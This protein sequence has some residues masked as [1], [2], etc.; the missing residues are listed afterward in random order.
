[1]VVKGLNRHDLGRV[2]QNGFYQRQRLHLVGKHLGQ[3]QGNRG[4][5][6]VPDQMIAVLQKPRSNIRNLIVYIAFQ[7]H[8]CALAMHRHIKAAHR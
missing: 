5:K 6:A 7:G 4:P 3:T 8:A 1:M 2:E